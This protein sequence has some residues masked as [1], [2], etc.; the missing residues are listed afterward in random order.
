MRDR[1]HHAGMGGIGGAAIQAGGTVPRAWI[2][3]LRSQ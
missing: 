3:S 2:A 1:D